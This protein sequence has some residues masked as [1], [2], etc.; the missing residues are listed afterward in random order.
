MNRKRM[1]DQS[2]RRIAGTLLIAAMGFSGFGCFSSANHIAPNKVGIEAEPDPEIR[3]LLNRTVRFAWRSRRD[4]EQL[5]EQA[6]EQA[7]Q[8]PHEDD[9]AVAR[10]HALGVKTH[11][12]RDPKVRRRVYG[13]ALKLARKLGGRPLE[14]RMIKEIG[15]SGYRARKLEAAVEILDEAARRLQDVG[16]R[17]GAGEALQWKASALLSMGRYADAG[18]P[19]R[20]A[21]DLF[22]ESKSFSWAAV[23]DA[24]L[25]F[26]DRVDHARAPVF[27][28]SHSWS[29]ELIRAEDGALTYAGRVRA[30][31]FTA[32][33]DERMFRILLF[34]E[35]GRMEELVNPSRQV[36]DT[37]EQDTR[38]FGQ[39]PLQT[40]GTVVGDH[41]QVTVPAGTFG[42]C[43][44]IRTVTRETE[45]SQ[46]ERG[47]TRR[48]NRIYCGVREVCYAPG[49]G[50]VRL[51]IVRKDGINTT[52]VLKDYSIR[53][54][55][56]D[57][58]PLDVGNRWVYGFEGVDEEDYLA[59]QVFQVRFN[60][61]YGVSH[62]ASY[63]YAHRRGEPPGFRADARVIQAEYTPQNLPLDEPDYVIAHDRIFQWTDHARFT[64][65]S[66]ETVRIPVEEND[67]EVAAIQVTPAVREEG[68]DFQFEAIDEGQRMVAAWP[69]DTIQPGKW[70][71]T[72]TRSRFQLDYLIK[73]RVKPKVTP[74]GEV[75]VEFDALFAI[76]PT[77]KEARQWRAAERSEE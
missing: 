61:A 46:S 62:L 71:T 38:S 70:S 56:R 7:E 34:D 23:C 53:N 26:I 17:Q 1:S 52:L 25:G 27:M 8:L 55:T 9:R 30:G 75:K 14:A 19:Y 73:I 42:D 40:V 69:F 63:T 43:R 64:A 57:Y 2:V 76:P 77:R 12:V 74:V 3:R 47:R 21:R 51:R 68:V 36:G 41:K 59:E 31:G 15:F 22:I 11:V 44:V 49:V 29:C 58:L 18:E 4:A 32:R 72:V 60:D 67:A 45:Q 33:G 10:M 24:A 37:W 28:T 20:R 48:L 35:A 54:T 16:D 6:L 39:Y 65:R 13:E 5:I 50:I 66:G